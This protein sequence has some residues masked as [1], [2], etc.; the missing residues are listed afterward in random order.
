MI[1]IIALEIIGLRMWV[2][3]SEPC[4]MQS[5]LS[6]HFVYLCTMMF[7]FI[8]FSSSQIL[9]R[10]AL[11]TILWAKKPHMDDYTKFHLVLSIFIQSRPFHLDC[12]GF[13][14][15]YILWKNMNI[16]H[17]VSFLF[18]DLNITI[19]S[20]NLKTLFLWVTYF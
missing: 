4:K 13:L 12:E 2:I 11:T 3:K 9:K 18:Q 6:C 7:Y 17:D 14:G 20:P 8:F 10:G 5:S 16:S 19:R 15:N 1:N